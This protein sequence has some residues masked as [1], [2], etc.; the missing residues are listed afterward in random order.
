MPYAGARGHCDSALLAAVDR[1]W[2]QRFGSMESFIVD[3][4]G[5]M[6]STCFVEE[7][8][9]GAQVDIRAPRQHGRFLE[10]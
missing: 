3:G 9:R 5:G 1:S 10:Q 8:R 4:E 2:I 6:T 7:T